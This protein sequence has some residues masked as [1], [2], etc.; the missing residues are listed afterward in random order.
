[1]IARPATS[2]LCAHRAI[3]QPPGA[4]HGRPHLLCTAPSRTPR[5]LCT[6][7]HT[8]FACAPHHLASHRTI[9]TAAHIPFALDQL[10][11]ATL[12]RLAA[13]GR[14]HGTRRL[15][16]SAT[17]S[18][19]IPPGALHRRP[20]PTLSFVSETAPTRHTRPHPSLPLCVCTAQTC[21]HRAITRHS[22]VRHGVTLRDGPPPPL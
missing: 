2:P 22:T 13:I 16:V 18:H 3:S 15:P 12:I 14:S 21:S 8:P 4:L 5:S 17:A 19:R 1:M 6:A 7:G 10:T 9:C 11:T 20:H